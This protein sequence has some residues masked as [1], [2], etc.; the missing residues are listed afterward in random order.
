VRRLVIVPTVI[1]LVWLAAMALTPLDSPLV[2]EA[3]S[4]MAQPAMSRSLVYGGDSQFPPYEYL[5]EDGNPAGFNIQLIRAL[6]REAGMSIDVRLGPREERMREFDAGQTDVMFL[7]Y[8]E[9]RA[10]RYQ[11]LDQTWTL[12]QVV[13]MR[14]GLARYPHGLDDLWGVK[15]AVDQNSINHQLLLALPESR[16][17]ALAVVK[18]REDQIRAFERGEVDGVA[19][20]HLTLR[21]LMGPLAETA[22][23]VPLISRPYHLAVLKGRDNIVAPLRVALDRLKNNGEFDRLVEQ[24]LS[25]PVRRSWI[26]RYAW[27]LTIGGAVVALLFAGGTAWNRSLHRQVQARTKAVERTE[28]RYRDLVDNASDMIY[29][30]DPFGR[31]TF[32]NPVATRILGYDEGELLSMKY[33]ELM[34]PDWVPRA[35]S[36][37]E[38][39]AKTRESTYLEFP[40]RKK[41]GTEI[42]VGQHV[43]P[44]VTGG[45]IEGFQGM[46]R[47]ITDRVN[48]QTDLRAERDFVSALLDTAPSLIMV[49]DAQGHIVRFNRACE[50]LSGVSM[51]EVAGL[52]SWEVPFL[53]DEDRNHVRDGIPRLAA[54]DQPVKLDRTW[55][56]RDGARH[57]IAWTIRALRAPTGTTSYLIGLGS[58]VTMTRE[59]ERL[60]SQFISMVSHELRT[61]LTSIRASMQ[62]LLAEDMTGNE[63][64]EQL[65][66]VALSNADRLIRIV[67]DILDMS[68]IEAGEMMVTPRRTRLGPIIEDSVRS[69]EAFARDNGVTISHQPLLPGNGAAEVIADPDRTIQVL[70]NLLSNAVKHSPSGATVEVT[71]AREG[72]MAAIAIRDHGPGIP[73]HKVDFIFEPFTQLD[74]SD[75]RR[76][77]GT[78]LGL[79]IARALAEKQGGGIRVS[80]H[81]G[82]GATFTL[83]M[84]IA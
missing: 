17:P 32:V 24:Y 66:R 77:A 2:A 74:G 60:K 65:V 68:K 48:A 67:N 4:A 28:R 38:K 76:I 29:R 50:E 20:N 10:A 83:T 7:S 31:F 82:E 40:V 62:L 63:D 75:T 55:I 58:D 70:I 6:A 44:I 23:E 11:L 37:Y 12:A 15:I 18:T 3:R 59:L 69:V 30:T 79:T 61:P 73:A 49:L 27:I 22:I 25:S 5:D 1:G 71:T 35:M 51:S 41:D 13:M 46:A 19:G 34:R 33:F 47:D 39:S 14:P 45:R 16:R 26:E 8:T 72:A 42:W 80:S 43:R 53:L 81:E 9:E 56:G 21:F 52:P 64:G 57:T 78:G 54:S 36:F 84:P